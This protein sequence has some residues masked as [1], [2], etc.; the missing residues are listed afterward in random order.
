DNVTRGGEQVALIDNQ[1]CSSN[2]V[3]VPCRSVKRRK[4]ERPE[5]QP[6]GT[7]DLP[8]CPSISRKRDAISMTAPSACSRSISSRSLRRSPSVTRR[9]ARAELIA[10]NS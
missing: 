9:L 2:V 5:L 10:A 7:G 4:E 6:H 1:R 3:P 8:Y